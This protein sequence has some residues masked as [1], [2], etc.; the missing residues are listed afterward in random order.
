[1]RAV[2]IKNRSSIEGDRM[3]DAD[4]IKLAEAIDRDSGFYAPNYD[5]PVFDPENDANDDYA[6]LEWAKG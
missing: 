6:V 5:R 2:T 3:S 1:M 4:R